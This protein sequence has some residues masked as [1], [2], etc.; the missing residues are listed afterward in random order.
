MPG[1][2]GKMDEI[3]AAYG[4]LNLKY[5]DISIEKRKATTFQY[6]HALQNISGIKLMD[7][8]PN[9]KHNYTYFPIFI[10]ADKYGMSRDE[11]Y[12]KLKTY[13]I[14]GRRYFYPLISEFP[15]YS[16]LDSAVSSNLPIATKLAK[17]VICLPLHHDIDEDKIKFIVE[18]ISNH[19]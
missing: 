11:L 18:I 4:L 17:S 1:I 12:E 10:D 8:M 9:T 14:F 5:I 15:I 2:N 6:R 16:N 3:R 7:D 13:N 19:Q